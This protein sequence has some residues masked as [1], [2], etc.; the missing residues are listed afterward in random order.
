MQAPSPTVLEVNESISE[1]LLG[2]KVRC[3]KFAIHHHQMNNTRHVLQPDI[4]RQVRITFRNCLSDLYSCLDQL[5]VGIHLRLNP[6]AQ[7]LQNIKFWY[8]A[9]GFKAPDP[10]DTSFPPARVT[11][12][13]NWNN[14]KIQGLFKSVFGRIPEL[15]TEQFVSYCISLQPRRVR[16]SAGIDQN[17]LPMNGFPLFIY[18]L[19]YLRNCSTHRSSI[20]R[21]REDRAYIWY[22]VDG[23]TWT[24]KNSADSNNPQN[25]NV[26]GPLKAGLWALVPS[27]DPCL[28]NWQPLMTVL[29]N[30]LNLVVD[31]EQQV[32][33]LFGSE[34][35]HIGEVE[36]AYDLFEQNSLKIDNEKICAPGAGNQNRLIVGS[37]SVTEKKQHIFPISIHPNGDV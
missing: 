11:E 21:I 5:M 35:I 3:A 7:D 28:F 9:G 31:T 1:L 37:Q 36:T 2:V 18:Q 6:N 17:Y 23:G 16:N 30:M 27:S 29:Q 14:S 22:A 10:N 20:M 26:I 33:L 13:D 15:D 34:R 25:P 24:V 19:H 12:C 32:A 8:V 4:D